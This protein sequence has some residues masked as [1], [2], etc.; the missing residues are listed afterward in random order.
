MEPLILALLLGAGLHLANRFEQR[1]RIA[2]LARHLGRFPIERDMG[3]LVEG[4]LPALTEADPGRRT[5]RLQELQAVEQ[6]L[7]ARLQEFNDVF[8]TVWGEHVRVSRWPMAVPRATR[9]FPRQSFDL[10]EAFVIHGDGIARAVENVD[11]LTDRD[12][13]FRITAELLLMQHSCHWYC[14]SRNVAHARL[15][16]HH[17]S[18][19]AQVLAGVDERTRRA[20]LA[21]VGA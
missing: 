16:A 19:H 10:R 5:L 11:A 17:Q 15:L 18:S 13:A 9:M 21:L 2:L 14:R 6:R 3:T 20:Y 7:L 12:R 1:E 4:Y 8:K